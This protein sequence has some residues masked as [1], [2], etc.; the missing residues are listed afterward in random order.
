MH[1]FKCNNSLLQHMI[2]FGLFTILKKILLLEISP[3]LLMLDP[4]PAVHTVL[5]LVIAD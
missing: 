3:D 4:S 5:G 1:V 2:I